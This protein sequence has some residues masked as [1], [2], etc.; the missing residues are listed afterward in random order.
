M[1]VGYLHSFSRSKFLS[2]VPY[3]YSSILVFLCVLRGEC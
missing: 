2:D 1:D 3:F